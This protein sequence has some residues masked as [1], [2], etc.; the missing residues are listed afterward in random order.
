MYQG[1][2]PWHSELYASRQS[3]H[4][5]VR[6][7]P[8]CPCKVNPGWCSITADQ[9]SLS[10]KDCSLRQSLAPAQAFPALDLKPPKTYS[11]L[12]PMLQASLLQGCPSSWNLCWVS[13]SLLC[14]STTVD[15]WGHFHQEVLQPHGVT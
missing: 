10:D 14:K 1:G 3:E 4:A 7:V 8:R 15:V 6:L 2:G 12:R 13:P 5:S 11:R 9:L